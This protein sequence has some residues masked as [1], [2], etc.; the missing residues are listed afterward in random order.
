MGNMLRPPQKDDPLG[1]NVKQSI[2]MMIVQE[3]I[4]RCG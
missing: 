4:N 2:L 3:G 1:I